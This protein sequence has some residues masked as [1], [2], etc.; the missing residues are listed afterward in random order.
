MVRV[1]FVRSCPGSYEHWETSTG[2][3]EGY[4][5]LGP[6]FGSGVGTSVLA[7]LVREC[8]RKPQGKYIAEKNVSL[9]SLQPD[10]LMVGIRR[11]VCE[12]QKCRLRGSNRNMYHSCQ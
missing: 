1:L 5:F 7:R 11:H 6:N 12:F 9:A 3:F 4:S 8:R 2:Q 10:Y